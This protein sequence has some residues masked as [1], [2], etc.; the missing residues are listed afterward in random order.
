[1][2]PLFNITINGTYVCGNLTLTNE[3]G[4][5]YDAFL[6]IIVVLCFYALSLVLLM[7]KYIRREEEELS[8]NFYYTEFVKREAFNT[9]DPFIAVP[10]IPGEQSLIISVKIP[11]SKH[12]FSLNVYDNGCG[13]LT[14]L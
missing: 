4:W 6:Y 12:Q 7:V 3:E 8:L 11:E 1:V 9:Y 5:T 13:C 14:L 10:V 2:P